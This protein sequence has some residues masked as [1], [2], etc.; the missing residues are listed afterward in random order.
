MPVLDGFE[1][2]VKIRAGEAGSKFQNIPII[3][4]TADAFDDSTRRALDLGMNDILVKPLA[5]EKL[6]QLL[7]KYSQLLKEAKKLKTR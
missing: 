7:L 3:G 4:V 1:A 6:I 2:T 5:K